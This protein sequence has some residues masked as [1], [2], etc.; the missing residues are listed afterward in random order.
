[1]L[2]AVQ[3]LFTCS[4]LPT[5]VTKPKE[6]REVPQWTKGNFQYNWIGI[7]I[8]GVPPLFVLLG[9]SLRVPLSL[10]LLQWLVFFSVVTGMVGVTTGYHRLFSHGAF[11]GGQ[12]M[13][14][15]CAFIGA[16]AFQGSIKWWARNHRVHHKYTDT[17]KDPYDARRGFFFSHFGWFIMRMDYDLLGNADV[18]DLKDSLLVE[19]QRKYFAVIATI[20]GILIPLMV[21]GATTGE[22]AGAFFWVV[23]LKIFIVH[24]FSFFINSLAHTDLFGATRPYS[25]DMTPHDSIIFAI[26]NLGEGY[27]NFHHQ[28]PK[29]YRNGHK[30]HHIDVTKW[31]IFICSFLGFCDNLQRVPRAVI[32]R[33]AATQA[34]RTRERELAEAAEEVRRLEVPADVE[35]TW[36]DV[37]AEVNQ[38]R[39]LIVMDS[40]V[41]DLERPIPVNPA[42]AL[43]DYNIKWMDAHPGGQALLLAYVGKDATAAFNG[44]V[45]EHTTGAHNY[46][47]ELRVG[48]MK[49]CPGSAASGTEVNS[50]GRFPR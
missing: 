46:L 4:V 43:I 28:F 49:D 11:T 15:M 7:Y 47:P 16:G 10:P 12:A 27:H 3:N 21:A 8:I 40:Y 32:D 50:T 13:Q 22:W 35:Y 9:L 36:D 2:Q 29:D 48:R 20:T 17:P 44:G 19:F 5:N 39:K 45:Y 30:W 24:Q 31:Y 26:V 42:W 37:R 38:G 23:W 6:E 34:V 25:D 1:M 14:W 18:S 41:L 33:A